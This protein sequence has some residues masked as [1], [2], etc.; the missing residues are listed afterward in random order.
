MW[1]TS[2]GDRTLQGSEAVL[3][4]AAVDTLLGP[5]VDYLDH[6]GQGDQESVAAVLQTGVAV[7]D[8]L[9]IAQ[10]I[11]ALHH[12]AVHL[13]SDKPFPGDCLSAADDATVAAIYSEVRDQVE[14]EI[15]LC[16]DPLG[17]AFLKDS[18][19]LHTE[20][21]NGARTSLMNWRR[22]VHR[23]CC[24]VL[25]EDGPWSE[26][27]SLEELAKLEIDEWELWI[28]CLASAILWDRDFEF[29]DTFMDADPDAAR[30]RRVALGISDDYFVRPAPD[31]WPGE[32]GRLIKRTRRL[33]RSVQATAG[34]V[35]RPLEEEPPF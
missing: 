32:I 16:N 2:E 6:D 26:V 7:F 33:V 4:A 28:D 31:P 12:A 14:I 24:E 27:S 35:S 22:L 10:R 18:A 21:E 20:P 23:A 30:R 11:A 13:L 15:D 25:D 5:L 1:P 19:E 8:T 9:P 34:R 17:D 29:A 3:L